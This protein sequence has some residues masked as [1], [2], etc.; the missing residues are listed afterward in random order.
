LSIEVIASIPCF[1][2]F[3]RVV[4]E[5]LFRLFGDNLVLEKILFDVSFIPLKAIDSHLLTPYL[6]RYI[7]W[8]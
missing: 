1:E 8:T 3:A 5:S 4:A 6:Y 2:D 7:V